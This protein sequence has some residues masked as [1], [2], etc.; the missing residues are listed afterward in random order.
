MVLGA[1]VVAVVQIRRVVGTL[2]ATLQGVV[3]R[4]EPLVEEL[5]AEAAVANVELEQLRARFEAVRD[6]AGRAGPQPG[7]EVDRR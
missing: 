3:E 1:A 7:S 2:S 6:E 4:L 5:R